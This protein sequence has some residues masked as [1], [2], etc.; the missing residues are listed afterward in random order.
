[1]PLIKMDNMAYKWCDLMA[2]TGYL[3]HETDTTATEH[4]D[5][6]ERPSEQA[7]EDLQQ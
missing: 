4:A 6:T 1:M 5:K 2:H 7:S 3:Q